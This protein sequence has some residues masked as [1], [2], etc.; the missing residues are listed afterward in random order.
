MI[1]Q[2]VV[3]CNKKVVAFGLNTA[4]IERKKFQPPEGLKQNSPGLQPWEDVPKGQG[5][6]SAT[7]RRLPNDGGSLSLPAPPLT[8]KFLSGSLPA[9][10]RA[11]IEVR[12]FGDSW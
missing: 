8:P 6:L 9:L 2:V 4:E 3:T 11:S 12:N 5:N 10:H 7:V 1:S